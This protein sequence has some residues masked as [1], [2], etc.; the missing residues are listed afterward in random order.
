MMLQRLVQTTVSSIR[1][2]SRVPETSSEADGLEEVKVRLESQLNCVEEEDE[3][4]LMYIYCYLVCD[5]LKEKI[6]RLSCL[7]VKV[8]IRLAIQL[9][10]LNL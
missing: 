1:T 4:V 3:E 5:I 9:N 6:C 7:L 2:V 8:G 10:P